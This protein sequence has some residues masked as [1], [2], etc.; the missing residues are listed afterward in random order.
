ML[1]RFTDKD[2]ATQA[3]NHLYLWN[4][5]HPERTSTTLQVGIIIERK[6]PDESIVVDNLLFVIHEVNNYLVYAA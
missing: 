1:V 4:V 3:V 5:W 6:K 2:L